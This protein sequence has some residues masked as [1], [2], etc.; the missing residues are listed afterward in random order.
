MREVLK[1]IQTGKFAKEW[2]LE[3]QAN[4]PQFNAINRMEQE[5]PIEEVGRELRELMPFIRKPEK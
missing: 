2:L 5:H 3:N 4:R 1:D